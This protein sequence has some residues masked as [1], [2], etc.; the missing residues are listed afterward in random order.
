M[1]PGRNESRWL[2]RSLATGF[3]AALAPALLLAGGS[4]ATLVNVNARYTVEAIEI[5]SPSPHKISNRLQQDIG[6]LVGD[7]LNPPALDELARR[8]RKELRVK[9][10][11]QKLQR[12]TQPDSVRVVFEVTERRVNFDVSIPKFVYHSRQGWTSAVEGET[13]I[14]SHVLGFGL[15]SDGDELV[16]RFAGLRAR[17]ENRRLGSERVRFGFQFESYHEQW[18]RATLEAVGPRRTSAGEPEASGNYRMRQNFQPM[19]TVVLAQPLTLSVGT[20]F[21]RFGVQFPAARTEAANAVVNT[22]RYHRTVEDSGSNKHDVDAGYSLRA[23]TR[24]LSSDYAYARHRWSFAYL[25]RHGAHAVGFDASAG[26]IS[27]RAPLF[28][29][30][31]LGNSTTLRGWNKFDLDPLGGDRFV[32]GSIEYRY[33][34]FEIFHDTGAIWNHGRRATVHQSVGGGLRK[35]GFYLAVAFPVKEGRIEPMLMVGMNY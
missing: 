18:N 21:E 32:H 7:K 8:I 1:N 12:G 34:Y 17:Y 11:S 26:L 6:N 4:Q 22:L 2:P 13:A 19:L 31:V 9:A 27:G 5:S 14:G 28:E 15:V 30:F 24:F 29:R 23:A 10:V 25:F 33:K 3:L 20:S 35:D 16:E